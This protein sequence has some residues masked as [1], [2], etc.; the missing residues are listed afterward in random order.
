MQQRLVNL[1]I[2][3]IVERL[4]YGRQ[5]AVLNKLGVCLKWCGGW[6]IVSCFASFVALAL[7]PHLPLKPPPLKLPHLQGHYLRATTALIEERVDIIYEDDAGHQ[8]AGKVDRTNR[9]AREE[10]A[11]H[12]RCVMPT[13]RPDTRP[14]S[15]RSHSSSTSPSLLRCVPCSTAT[16]R[17]GCS[18]HPPVSRPPALGRGR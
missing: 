12:P 17:A 2:H 13:N 11:S 4:R 7:P 16:T 18:L 8:Q 1:T 9:R 5:F 6:S 3:A 14:R 10:S 15:T